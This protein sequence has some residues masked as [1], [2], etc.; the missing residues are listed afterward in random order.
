MGY[1]VQVT[2][3]VFF[4]HEGEPYTRY[5]VVEVA[6]GQ[7]ELQHFLDVPRVPEEHQPYMNVQGW[8]FAQ[9]FPEG[10]DERGVEGLLEDLPD[11]DDVDKTEIEN[12]WDSEEEAKEFYENWIKALQWCESQMGLGGCSYRIAGW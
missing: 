9:F 12:R 3:Q 11:W 5:K 7:R 1:D 4:T 8:F 2:V 10:K 6:G